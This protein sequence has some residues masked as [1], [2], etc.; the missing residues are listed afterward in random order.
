MAV[1]YMDHE[2]VMKQ[3]RLIKQDTKNAKEREVRKLA[4]LLF[5]A[6]DPRLKRPFEALARAML[7]G[8]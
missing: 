1:V 5:D 6:W 2:D 8:K 3:E 4:R 7:A